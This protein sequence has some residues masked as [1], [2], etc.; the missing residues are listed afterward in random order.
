VLDATVYKTPIDIVRPLLYPF[1][2]PQTARMK[3]FTIIAPFV[4]LL[5]ATVAADE[6]TQVR[7]PLHPHDPVTLLTEARAETTA[8]TL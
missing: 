3:A 5:A 8:A 7:N 6:C 4:A 1:I 2:L